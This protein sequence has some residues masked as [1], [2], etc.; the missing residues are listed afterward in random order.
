MSRN[1]AQTFAATSAEIARRLL[2]QSNDA[3]DAAHEA[4]DEE[5][6]AML[7]ALAEEASRDAFK[8]A[9]LSERARTVGEDDGDQPTT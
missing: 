9:A 1:P 8:W 5:L 6:R 4:P 3:F 2:L 7:T